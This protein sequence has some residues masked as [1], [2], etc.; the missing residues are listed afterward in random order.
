LINLQARIVAATD[1]NT[2]FGPCFERSR[3]VEY[4][5]SWAKILIFNEGATFLN[6]QLVD[7]K[8]RRADK[9]YSCW[10]AVRLEKVR[11]ISGKIQYKI[12]K[13]MAS[14]FEFASNQHNV[15]APTT[16]EY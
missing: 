11:K 1:K 6:V 7:W 10:K 12:Q 16:F 2:C 15:E 4:F 5:E 14:N 9:L 8:I 13:E 3:R